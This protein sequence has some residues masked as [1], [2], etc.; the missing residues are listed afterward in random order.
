MMSGG[1]MPHEMYEFIKSSSCTPMKN[2]PGFEIK[3]TISVAGVFLFITIP[4]GNSYLF[5]T[6]V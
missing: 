1:A 5:E 6:Y 4:K 2:T 3:F